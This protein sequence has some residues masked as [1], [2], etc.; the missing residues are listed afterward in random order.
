MA[1]SMA[2]LVLSRAGSVD[3]LGISRHVATSDMVRLLTLP[4]VVFPVAGSGVTGTTEPTA[5]PILLVSKAREFL[6]VPSLA[7]FTLAKAMAVSNLLVPT[8]AVIVSGL[9]GSDV[10]ESMAIPSVVIS[11]LAVL[12]VAMALPSL[13]GSEA[14]K[15]MT[16]PGLVVPTVVR[17][18]AVPGLIVPAVAKFTVLPDLTVPT[19]DK[20]LA[21]PSLISRAGNSAPVSSWDVFGVAKLIAKLGLLVAIV[22]KCLAASVLVS[23]AVKFTAVLALWRRPRGLGIPLARGLPFPGEA[24]VGMWSVTETRCPWPNEPGSARTGALWANRDWKGKAR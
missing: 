20:S 12:L 15:S 21:V 5:V 9:T 14:I 6:A 23:I 3:L 17:F 8:V 19:E 11:G 24:L 16:I 10:A 4:S 2:A 7:L 13:S 18:M 1:L 22:A